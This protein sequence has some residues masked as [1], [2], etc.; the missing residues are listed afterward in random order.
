VLRVTKQFNMNIAHLVPEGTPAPLIPLMVVIESV[1]FIIRPF[2]LA[3]R[4]G[5]NIIAGHLLLT[6]L[7]GQ[8]SN[9][10]GVILVFLIV[11]IFGL[12]ALEGAVACIQAY[13]FTILSTLY[14]NEHNSIILSKPK[15]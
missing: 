15:I 13:V 12:I 9:L 6:L 14:L 1:S 2:T 11:A 4:L 7:G 10:S 3:V 8:G 5:A